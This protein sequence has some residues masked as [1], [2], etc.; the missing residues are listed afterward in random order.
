MSR[1]SLTAIT[2]DEQGWDSNINDNMDAIGTTPFAPGLYANTGA[3]PN[4]GAYDGCIAAVGSSAPY[5]IYMSTGS[6]WVHM[7]TSDG[8]DVNSLTDNSGGSSGGDTIAAVSSVATAADAVATLAAK[9]NSVIARLGL[10][11]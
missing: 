5:E 7:V 4:P 8:T 6:A 3:L 11:L 2:H 10:D 9:L 1:P